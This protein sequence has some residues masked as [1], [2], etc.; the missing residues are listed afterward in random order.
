VIRYIDSNSR[1]KPLGIVA[2]LFNAHPCAAGQ[3]TASHCFPKGI[4][5]QSEFT[6]M[7]PFGKEKAPTL[8]GLRQLDEHH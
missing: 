8:P 4:E 5:Y 7:T 1:H 2:L 3:W 6:S